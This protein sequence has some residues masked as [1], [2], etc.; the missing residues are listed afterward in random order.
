[1]TELQAGIG[2]RDI[3]PEAPMAL[4]GYPHVRR[5]STGVHDPLRAGALCLRQGDAVVVLVAVDILMISPASAS[6]I[7]T[8][9]S[10]Q[11]GAPPECVLVSCTHTHSGPIAC[12]MLGA[13]DDPTQPPP[14]PG[15]VGRLEAA[16]AAAA[17]DAAEAL[18]PAETAWTAACVE[19]VG[20]NRH[21]PAGP[22]DP[23]V[24]L[25][26][27]RRPGADRPFAVSM[28]YCMHP[29]VLH[30]DSTRISADFPCYAHGQLAEDV[31]AADGLVLYHTGPAGNQ[32]PRWHVSGQTF[33]EAERLG[34]TLGRAAVGS[35][36]ALDDAAFDSR[37]VLR[38][39]MMPVELVPRTLLTV[40]Q[41]EAL[42]AE[43][44]R[45]YET[46]KASGA[47]HGPVRTAECA[48][49]GAEEALTL[50]RAAGRGEVA[51]AIAARTPIPVAAIRVGGGVLV[52]LPGEVFVEY[53]L[54]IKRR[55]GGQTYVAS[56]VNGELQ[57]YIVTPEAEAAGGY[58]ASNGLFA[59]SSGE[60]LV[61]AAVELAGRLRHDD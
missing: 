29:T 8:A 40:D 52:G 5:V 56:L 51:E 39:A 11:T 49:F 14:E 38:G 60:V 16:V 37:A 6:R 17:A 2:R 3:T 32:S 28:T 36:R 59:A 24:G 9:I 4:A 27:V 13:Q 1:M 26:V 25:L 20:G 44:R 30:E 50:A 41:A 33:A 7:R 10:Q 58:E 42:L 54:A 34:R 47:A 48:V 55:A 12:G 15:Y 53:D 46:L 19:G 57:G 35:V 21:D 22:S 43:R 23:E 61:D 31:M 45:H 18:S